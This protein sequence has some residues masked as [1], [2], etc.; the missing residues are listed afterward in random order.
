MAGKSKSQLAVE[1]S[2]LGVQ[3]EIIVPVPFSLKF[4]TTLF[5]IDSEAHDNV[6]THHPIY[7]R[8]PF[9]ER[10]YFLL[11]PLQRRLFYMAVRKRIKQYI[12]QGGKIIH[13][14]SML[15]AGYVANKFKAANNCKSIVTFH[16]NEIQSL[17]GNIRAYRTFLETEIN[18]SDLIIFVS[19]NLRNN[20]FALAE[21][22]IN[23]EIIPFPIDHY[24]FEKSLSKPFTIVGCGR[25][26]P[27]KGFE[28]LI[29]AAKLLYLAGEEVKIRI[30]G[31]GPEK[32][33]LQNL[34]RQ[35]GLEKFVRFKGF[36]SNSEVI[37]EMSAAHL[38]VLPSYRESL[39]LVYLEA[40]SVS[41]P[42]IG[43]K[44]QG[45]EDFIING[46][47][48]YLM[49]AEDTGQL[50]SLI[51]KLMNDGNL[52]VR[53]GKNGFE[54]YRNSL[55]NVRNNAAYHFKLYERFLNE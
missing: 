28:T 14:H 1:L 43:V 17:S 51:Q 47:N 35:S 52:R 38:F 37:A 4:M 44:G 15:F 24:K 39:G 19:K 12:S 16:D 21:A 36:L 23:S 46:E 50:Y 34:V 8:L 22:R 20:Y 48:G 6:I 9:V 45:I 27:S 26:I 42:V 25:L 13:A 33:N 7:I 54:T 55:A 30:I 32:Q 11:N 40:M 41:T 29:A 49:D 5:R 18:K 3:V 2:K 10:F 31:E 53:I